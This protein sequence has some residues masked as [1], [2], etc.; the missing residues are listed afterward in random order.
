[1][2]ITSYYHR[3]STQLTPEQLDTS[4]DVKLQ[5]LNL[6]VKQNDQYYHELIHIYNI[7]KDDIKKFA[8]K[9]INNITKAQII[10]ELRYMVRL[11]DNKFYNINKL[12]TVLKQS[13]LPQSTTTLE[14]DKSLNE[15]FNSAIL[16]QNTLVQILTILSPPPP[17]QDNL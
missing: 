10:S 3:S 2:Q 1:M 13:L 11:V 12:N 8:I 17:K 7:C 4:Y 15:S 14:R 16:I 6:L 9:N 5:Q